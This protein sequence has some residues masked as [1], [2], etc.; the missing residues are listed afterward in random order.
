MTSTIVCQSFYYHSDCCPTCTVN[1]T[2]CRLGCW[3]SNLPRQCKYFCVT[4][5]Y[6]HS[7][8]FLLFYLLVTFMHLLAFSYSLLHANLLRNIVAWWMV[9]VLTPYKPLTRSSQ[10][11]RAWRFGLEGY[12]C[13]CFGLSY[14]N[15]FLNFSL[16][17]FAFN[18]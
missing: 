14:F 2:Y 8:W 12:I 18:I 1:S 17:T 13:V 6:F 5:L 10:Y 15:C 4:A 11:R 7:S 3:L 9:A 16:S